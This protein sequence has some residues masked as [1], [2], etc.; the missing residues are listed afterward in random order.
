M[1]RIDRAPC[2]PALLSRNPSK[3]RFRNKQVVRTLWEMQHRKCCYC[4]Q[5]IPEEGH[6]KAVEHFRPQSVYRLRRNDWRN[7]LLACPQCNG[8]KSDKFPV[9]LTSK[10]D[11]VK[12]VC[13]KRQS[14][15][16]PAM[17]DPSD[18]QTDPEKYLDYRVHM[19]DGA[20]AGQ[21]LPRK[22]SVLGRTTI[23][24]TGI[25]HVFIHRKRRRQ[26]RALWLTIITL[27]DSK[28]LGNEDHLQEARARV[29]NMMSS[30]HEFAGMA[31]ECA[32]TMSLDVEYG[33]AIPRIQRGE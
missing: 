29:E 10:F 31:R 22:N 14:D 8:R 33:V 3:D 11:E 16:P 19:S 30:A 1:I 26:L 15:A 27:G 32:R 4:E 6:A 12:I 5:E 23:E 21:V 20:L 9:I 2:P 13:L 28:D 7:L 25:D 17:I 24:I 18:G